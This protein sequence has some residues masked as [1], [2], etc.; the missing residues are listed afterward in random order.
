MLTLTA[1]PIPRTL[2]MSLIGLRD[3][4]SLNTPP[5]D[6][7]AIQT[8]LMRWDGER[9]R[10]P[11][12]RELARDGQVFFVHNRVFDIEE[13]AAAVR[14]I[15]PEAKLV[16]A[17]GQMSERELEARMRRFVEG[18]V[19]V[20]VSTTIIES[21]LDIPNANTIVINNAH[22]FG[23]ADLHQLRGRVG[24]YKHRA[25]AYLVIPPERPIA[26]A[27]QK[28]LK[29]IQEFAELGA[30]F[31]IAM[32]DL[33][34]RGAGNILGPEQHGHIAAVGYDMYC[35]LLEFAI[36]RRRGL[37]PPEEH[38]VVV[39]LG[40]EAY[41]PAE[42]MPDPRHRIEIYRRLSRAT[43]EQT[44]A[45]VEPELRDRFG[46]LPGVAHCLLEEARLRIRA[47]RAAVRAVHLDGDAVHL[48]TKEPDKTLHM[49]RCPKER[50]VK[51][52][53]RTIL[54]RL[55]RGAVPP[56]KPPGS[57]A[58]AL[59]AYLNSILPREAA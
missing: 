52:D 43:S 50:C 56:A 51:L 59:I 12:L 7:L 6:R 39:S 29:A 27:A 15:V 32:R 13:V 53:E 14:Q 5:R 20:L 47:R 58:E 24:R 33:E 55:P 44:V 40:Q 37:Q 17:H 9:I 45:E 57:A 28:R 31:K 26:P 30:G 49:L 2:H 36:R 35:R 38:S 21:G 54:L 16:V 41:L 10:L 4:S 23:L 22:D 25:Y 11:I 19:N 42:Y 34:I 1:T 18:D 48:H 3:I 46:R 8:R